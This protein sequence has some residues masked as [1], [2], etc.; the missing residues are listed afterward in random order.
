MRLRTIITRGVLMT[1]VAEVDFDSETGLF[2]SLTLADGSVRRACDL[3]GSGTYA[4]MFC[5]RER[6][7]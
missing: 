7:N 4:T 3:L 5:E 6:S 2:S 1:S